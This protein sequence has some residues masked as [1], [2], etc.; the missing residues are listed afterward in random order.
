MRGGDV[1]HLGRGV[2]SEGWSGQRL[3]TTASRHAGSVSTA[4]CSLRVSRMVGLVPE[5]QS[6][7]PRVVS[8]PQPMSPPS[9]A[10]GT[11][12][13]AHAP[14]AGAAPDAEVTLGDRGVRHRCIM[15]RDATRPTLSRVDGIALASVITSGVVGLCGLAAAVWSTHH[16]GKLVR[17]GRVQERRIDAYLQLLRLVERH[18]L[19]IERSMQGAEVTGDPYADAPKLP[20]DPDPAELATI[21]ALVAAF[22]SEKLRRVILQWRTAA[23]EFDGLLKVAAWNWEQDYSGPD[24]PTHPRDLD[25]LRAQCH[26]VTEERSAVEAVIAQEIQRVERGR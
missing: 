3:V 13:L 22:A 4:A 9:Q 14:R 11:G 10:I 6:A 19:W 25:N 24:T 2:L 15:P 8:C 21:D 26:V 20:V 23:A 18:T 12:C 16:N 17:E 1:E 7:P 5:T